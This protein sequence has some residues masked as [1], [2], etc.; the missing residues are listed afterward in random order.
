MTLWWIKVWN[1]VDIHHL[2]KWI[3]QVGSYSNDALRDLWLPIF[4]DLPHLCSPS[5]SFREPISC[6]CPVASASQKR[7]MQPLAFKA[8]K[9]QDIQT[10]QKYPA[11]FPVV[12]LSCLSC[13]FVHLCAARSPWWCHWSKR[14]P[15]RCTSIWR[16]TNAKGAAAVNTDL[17]AIVGQ[18]VQEHLLSTWT[19]FS[20]LQTKRSAEIW[21][22]WRNSWCASGRRKLGCF[23][24]G[25]SE[26]SITMGNKNQPTQ[27]TNNQQPHLSYIHTHIHLE[28]Y[29]DVSLNSSPTLSTKSWPYMSPS[30]PVVLYSQ[31]TEKQ[32]WCCGTERETV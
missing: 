20:F 21:Y 27:P 28:C 24:P 10:N 2:Q 29:I 31:G 11:S 25:F 30:S 8:S 4:Q 1:R 13:L 14:V 7:K 17:D 18:H 15:S 9:R 32:R 19:C 6:R 26:T 3:A 12:S 23:S 22:F 5:V 16:N